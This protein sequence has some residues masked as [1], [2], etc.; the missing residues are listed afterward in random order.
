MDSSSKSLIWGLPPVWLIKRVATQHGGPQERSLD[1]FCHISSALPCILHVPQA[2]LA[3]FLVSLHSLLLCFFFSSAASRL[4]LLQAL[5]ALQALFQP[6]FS[7]APSPLLLFFFFFF[8]YLCTF[9]SFIGKRWT[10]VGEARLLSGQF[11]CWMELPKNK[12]DLFPPLYDYPLP[13]F[14]P[15][16]FLGIRIGTIWYTRCFPFVLKASV[17]WLWESP[18]QR[19]GGYLNPRFF[20]YNFFFGSTRP[21]IVWANDQLSCIGLIDILIGLK[22]LYE[23]V[24]H[25]SH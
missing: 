13:L 14:I 7:T 18:T 16:F 20:F 25:L 2:L 21:S 9:M 19:Y 10:A 22:F 23:L 11:L 12:H 6:H 17:M 3:F 4:P 8:F 5:V 1:C 24:L 15:F